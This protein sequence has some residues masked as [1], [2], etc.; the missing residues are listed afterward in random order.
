[1]SSAPAS[2]GIRA[3][4]GSLR[5]WVTISGIVLIVLIIAADTYEGWQDYLRVITDNQHFQV[6][7]SRALTEQTARMVQEVDL[8]MSS[9]TDST[10]S[11]GG[12]DGQTMRA[13]FLS[14]IMRLPFIY[15][16]AIANADGELLA[17]SSQEPLA[18]LNMKDLGEFPRSA[19]AD[20]IDISRPLGSANSS[21]PTF[22]L[23]RRLASAGGTFAGVVIAR[24][25]VDYLARFYA[26]INVT[27][28]TRVRMVRA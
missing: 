15:S 22:A 3:D 17:K 18:T 13:R 4:A 12:A 8:V 19:G 10:L 5:R 20:V 1:M 25:S 28:D 9:Y 27:P 26:L 24:V 7:M 6:T 21:M 14:Q 2:A 11:A 23:S 16:A